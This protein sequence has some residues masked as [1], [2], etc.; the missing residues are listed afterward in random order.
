MSQA[1]KLNTREQFPVRRLAIL[2]KNDRWRAFVTR[3]CG[4]R[5]GRDLLNISTFQKLSSFRID[6]YLFDRIESVMRPIDVIWEDLGIELELERDYARLAGLYRRW[7]PQELFYPRHRGKL[8]NHEDSPRHPQFLLSVDN[9]KYHALYRYLVNDGRELS[10]P[11]AQELLRNLNSY[12]KTMQAVMTHVVM[13]LND[14]LVTVNARGG[15]KPPLVE[16]LTSV[17]SS[18][19]EVAVRGGPSPETKAKMLELQR[20][21]LAYVE[22]NAAA[23]TR[24][25]LSLLPEAGVEPKTY[26]D[27]FRL[28]IWRD[29]FAR[30]RELVGPRFRNPCVSGL[31]MVAMAQPLPTP[32]LGVTDVLQSVISQHPEIVG[33]PTLNRPEAKE[34]LEAMIERTLTQW[35]Q[36]YGQQRTETTPRDGELAPTALIPELARSRGASAS[37]TPLIDEEDRCQRGK[38]A[39][40]DS[41]STHGKEAKRKRAKASLFVESSESEEQSES[42]DASERRVYSLS[43]DVERDGPLRSIQSSNRAQGSNARRSFNTHEEQIARE[44]SSSRD[45]SLARTFTQKVHRIQHAEVA[46]ESGSGGTRQP[47][48]KPGSAVKS[49]RPFKPHAKPQ[50][51]SGR[52]PAA[53]RPQQKHGWRTQPFAGA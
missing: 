22:K 19:L 24:D 6:D 12:G 11:N 7:E 17:V 16:E 44:A 30:V 39:A 40:R 13:W 9:S 31:D 15:N 21:V 26:Q 53:A 38:G 20:T 2:W 52:P 32:N 23:F 14:D 27:R 5:A 46:S 10:F 28:D 33:N 35:K 25:D 51:G 50:S 8:E 47:A 49:N 4:R 43:P 29:V 42:H 45:I 1:L 34:A 48:C 36:R 18:M 41:A 3:L 37:E